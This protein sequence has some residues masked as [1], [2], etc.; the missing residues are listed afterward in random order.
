M[1]F[2]PLLLIPIAILST[3]AQDASASVYLSGQVFRKE[4][5]TPVPGAT[6]ELFRATEDG[7]IA[8]TQ[9]LGNGSYILK[10]P[11][12]GPYRIKV[13]AVHFLAFD[14]PV[15]VS[16]KLPQPFEISLT[17]EPTL[18]LLLSAAPG[19]P[20]VTGPV[21]ITTWIERGEWQTEVRTRTGNV[22]PNGLVEIE[23]PE[24]PPLN[25]IR[26]MLVEVT[27]MHGGCGQTLVDQWQNTPIK[28]SLEPGLS[29]SGQTLDAQGKP[30]AGNMIVIFRI[31]KGI[32]LFANEGHQ[33]ITT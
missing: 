32:P 24:G 8:M 14:G 5:R 28:V 29:F 17:R 23:A 6:V 15:V 22:S 18:S 19:A 27:S 31:L 12:P 11:H 2:P 16:K 20:P 3:A 13:T 25:S 4:L 9:T 30:A 7:A 26:K 1:K 33:M 21:S 10:V